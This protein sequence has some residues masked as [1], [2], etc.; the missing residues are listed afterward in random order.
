M[1]AVGSQPSKGYTGTHEQC[2]PS[3]RANR[4]YR[5]AHLDRVAA[6]KEAMAMQARSVQARHETGESDSRLAGGA[7]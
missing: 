7:R 3:A 5:R 6:V 1:A 2:E 4:S